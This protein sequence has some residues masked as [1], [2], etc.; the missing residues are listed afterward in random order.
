MGVDIGDLAVK[1]PTSIDSLSGRVIAVDAF[2]TLYQFLASIRQEDGTPLMDFKGRVTAHLSGLFYRTS[3]L[4][5]NGLKPVFVFDG[6]PPRF[7]KKTSEARS[8]TKKTAEEKWIQALE[9]K[10]FEDARKYAQATSRLTGEMVDESK[11]L[12][13]GMGVPWIQAPSEAE[14]QAA[15]MVQK[16]TA[17]AVS[18]QDY[19]SLLFGSPILIRNINIT[20]KRKVPRQDRY[21]TI[22]PEEI[23]LTE[24]LNS[25]GVDRKRLIIMG[26]LI[27]TD[28]NEGV[29]RVGPKTALKIIK[30]VKTLKSAVKYVK[31][32][33]D[34]EFEEYIEEVYDFFMKPPVEPVRRK[35]KW[36][37]MDKDKVI[38][39][40]C[41][42]H[43]FSQERVERTLNELEK[44]FNEKNTQRSLDN[45]F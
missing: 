37:E 25:L 2:N 1:N 35:F 10:R 28:F 11:L 5:N 39:F 18:S 29:R 45:W 44:T 26:I 31:E 32:K 12:L 6:K 17:Y 38:K 3:K 9:E 20:G 41:G 15:V 33:Y 19:D 4:L 16:G 22:E 14:A 13:D 23:K 21:I 40:L 36:G 8:E 30:E 27:G 24:T 7:K 43:D 34:Y 42:Q